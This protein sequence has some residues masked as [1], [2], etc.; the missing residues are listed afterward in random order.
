[1]ANNTDYGLSAT[2][3]TEDKEKARIAAYTI[4]SGNVFVNARG[5][6]GPDFP[7]GGIKGSGYGREC[8][9]DGVLEAANRKT[10]VYKK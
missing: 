8:F 6:T 4:R 9:S 1:L 3:F 2:I 7:S 10:I 5:Y